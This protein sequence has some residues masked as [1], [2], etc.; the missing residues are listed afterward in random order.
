MSCFRQKEKTV[1]HALCTPEEIKRK[2]S[3]QCLGEV[4]LWSCALSSQRAW[5]GLRRSEQLFPVL[6]ESGCA[7]ERMCTGPREGRCQP[8]CADTARTAGWS[9]ELCCHLTLWPEEVR[10]RCQFSGTWHRSHI[11][12]NAFQYLQSKMA[13]SEKKFTKP[14][15]TSIFTT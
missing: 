8:H 7:Q 9:P 2:G 1:F 15:E 13:I 6:M 10:Q 11:W 4:G 3:N 14:T 12:A 5:P